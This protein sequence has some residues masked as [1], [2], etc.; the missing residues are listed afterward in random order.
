LANGEDWLAAPEQAVAQR[1]S[2]AEGIV[3]MQPS[4]L[5]TA[6]L[7]SSLFASWASIQPASAAPSVQPQLGSR[8]APIVAVGGLRF[9][10]LNRNGR[11]D[12]YEDW[13]RPAEAR[14]AD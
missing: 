5:F 7:V 12:A 1:P 8:S 10:D 14:V 11:L 13:R 6:G 3:D 9:R 4:L 2:A